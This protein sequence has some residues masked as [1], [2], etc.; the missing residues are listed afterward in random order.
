MCRPKGLIELCDAYKKVFKKHTGKP[1]PQD[2][3]DATAN[4]PSRRS[5]P[6]GIRRGPSATAKSKNIRGLLGTA[7][8]V[9]SMVYG[10]MGDDSG[11]GVAFTRNPST[12][13]NKF[14]GEFLINA[15]GE[16]V[17][18]GIRTPQPV[19]EMPKWNKKVYKQLLEIKKTLE[20]HYRDMQDIEFTIERAS[21]S[22]CRRATA[23]G[24]APRRSRSPA[25]WSRETDRRE[26]GRPADSG[27]RPDATAA[28]QL[29]SRR[30]RRQADVLT[31]GL[32]ASPGRG[33]GQAGLHGR[34]S[35]RAD[36]RPAKACCWSAKKPAPKTSTAC[37]APPA[38]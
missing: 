9:Q 1:F 3:F 29:R 27:Q 36:G 38:F 19:D 17:V 25:T 20:K 37:T 35:R 26:D 13:E 6:A 21:C 33:R 34:R 18:A 11:T 28:A 4:W 5:S 7:V 15:Q 31:R 12:G 10:N 23:S 30:P 32:P 2:P 24:P 14:Y 16:D 22:C 8:N